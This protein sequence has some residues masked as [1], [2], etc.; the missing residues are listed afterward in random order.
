MTFVLYVFRQGMILDIIV[1]FLISMLKYVR[2]VDWSLS[3]LEIL[4]S[5]LCN[6]LQGLVIHYKVLEQGTKSS[7]TWNLAK[8]I[9]LINYQLCNRL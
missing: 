6:R 5:T 2:Q 9:K 3:F 1:V 4:S 7:S 8:S